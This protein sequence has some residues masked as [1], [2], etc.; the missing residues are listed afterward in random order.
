MNKR[1]EV[2]V[3]YLEQTTRPTAP[4]P[5]KPARPT[6]I[7][8]AVAPPVHFY[9]YLYNLV[10]TPW[11][12]VSRRT[13]DDATLAGI[14]HDEDVY[15]YVFYVHGSPAGFAEIDARQLKSEKLCE[16]K[17]FGLSPDMVGT[18]LGRFF[19]YNALEIAW[20]LGPEKVTLETCTLDHPAAL[21]LYQKL[22]FNVSE[23]RDGH[24]DLPEEMAT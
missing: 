22:G 1:I 20:G 3:T 16:L 5:P 10:G 6:A 23:R 2:T 9:R 19:L 24:V 8:R 18:G 7:M 21:P 12:W 14:I 11:K 15:I 17:F 4:P 13:M